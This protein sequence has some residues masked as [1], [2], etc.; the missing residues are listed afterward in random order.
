MFFGNKFLKIAYVLSI[1][2]LDPQFSGQTKERLSSRECAGF[3]QVV[4]DAI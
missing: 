3:S 2:I 1:K 4:T